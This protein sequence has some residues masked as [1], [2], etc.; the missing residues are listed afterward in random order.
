M[1]SERQVYI[2]GTQLLLGDLMAAQIKNH[3]G[4]TCHVVSHFDE[5]RPLPSP[6]QKSINLHLVDCH[7]KDY[8]SVENIIFDN[9]QLLTRSGHYALFNLEQNIGVEKK[10]LSHGAKGFFYISDR[11]ETILLGIRLILEG[12]LWASRKAMTECLFSLPVHIGIEKKSSTTLTRR[13]TEILTLLIDGNDNETIASSLYISPH[14][15]RTHLHHI[16][17]KLRVRNR[18]QAA[19]WASKHL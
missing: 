15:V 14:T 8:S 12:E 1:F 7:G 5:I 10:A 16:F 4:A 9:L 19:H 17:K 2:I 11:L 3:T 6:P 13:E 18:L